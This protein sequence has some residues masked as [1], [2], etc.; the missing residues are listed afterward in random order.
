MLLWSGKQL[1]DR[2]AE[3]G[4]YG[5][6]ENDDGEGGKEGKGKWEGTGKGKSKG[7]TKY[8]GRVH[9][10]LCTRAFWPEGGI[11]FELGEGDSF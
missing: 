7:K 6:Y 8:K 5:M 9:A 2:E 10:V 3:L 11:P 1:R 4:S